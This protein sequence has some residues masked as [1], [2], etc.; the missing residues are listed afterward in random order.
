VNRSTLR[1]LS[2]VL[3]SAVVSLFPVAAGAQPA[4]TSMTAD[5]VRNE[6]LGLG[7]QVGVPTTWWT[8]NHV[9][10][11]TVADRSGQGSASGRILMVLVYPDT[12]TAQSEM[13]NAQAREAAENAD[14]AATAGGPHLV[15]GY[16]P[17]IL[18]NNV[19][20]VESTQQ[21][22]A[23]LYAAELDRDNLVVVGT[24]VSMGSTSVPPTHAVDLDFLSALDR[25][26][27][28]L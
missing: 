8:N 24:G 4:P 9:T 3:A 10:T 15:A 11:F 5:Q 6:F 19:A 28:N 22:L 12:A 23:R 16:G 21:E 27:A 25:S 13:S 2:V 26:F 14:L 7:Y 20:L 18:L 1:S 17:S